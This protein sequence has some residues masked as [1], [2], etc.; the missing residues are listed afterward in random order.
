MVTWLNKQD[1]HGA[2]IAMLIATLFSFAASTPASAQEISE[3]QFRAEI[4][5]RREAAAALDRE[6]EPVAWA[7][8]QTELASL[9]Q[10]LSDHDSITESVALYRA[11]L[12]VLTPEATP[13]EWLAA[14][15]GLG[16]VLLT[17]GASQSMASAFG[18]RFGGSEFVPSVGSRDAAEA[19]RTAL[20][21]RT[22]ER[23]RAAWVRLQVKLGLALTNWTVSQRFSQAESAETDAIQNEA[24]SAFR[25]AL[26]A[27]SLRANPL[28]WALANEGLA[29]LYS[30]AA[31]FI[32][33][34]YVEDEAAL[35]RSEARRVPYVRAAMAATREVERAY[36]RSG[37]QERAQDA[38]QRLE[39]LREDL[40]T[41]RRA[42]DW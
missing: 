37:D 23:D 7:V 8:A 39:R 36:Q 12:E 29:L 9:L 20:N 21:F 10:A 17:I 27:L 42:P 30:Q 15:E 14:E 6:N 31:M 19:F 25:H 1:V 41:N 33:L 24:E 26:S 4:A 40:R 11:A 38:R 2:L 35:R 22:R 18:M 34:E 3:E 16:D 32:G 28:E 5:Q 13:A